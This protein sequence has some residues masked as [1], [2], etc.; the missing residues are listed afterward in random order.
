MTYEI[1]NLQYKNI[2]K[3]KN[4]KFADHKINVLSG[5]SGTGKTTLFSLLAGKDYNYQGDIYLNNQSIKNIHLALLFTKIAYLEQEYLLLSK[6]VQGEF[7]II[8]SLLGLEYNLKKI[9]SL[10]TLVGLDVD[11]L[12]STIKFSGGEKQRLAI[13]RTLYPDRDVILLDEPTSALDQKTS[14]KFME[15][16]NNYCQEHQKT[17]LLISH[18]DRITKNQSFNQI[19]LGA[20][21]E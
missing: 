18:E 5:R 4:L 11:I 19:N 16:L 13:A 15:N 6:T 17:V 20:Y 2:L 10:L 7:E 3:I 14:T 12:D 21:N 8:C 9:L 1:T